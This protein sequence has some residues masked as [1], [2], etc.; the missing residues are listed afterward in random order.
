[1]T[2][3]QSGAA[4]LQHALADHVPQTD[5]AALACTSG[6]GVLAACDAAAAAWRRIDGGDGPPSRLALAS[7]RALA[8]GLVTAILSGAGGSRWCE[9]CIA[10]AGHADAFLAAYPAARVVCL[11]RRCLDVISAAL[12][13]N[14]WGLD[15]TPFGAFASAYPGNAVAAAAAYWD[16]YTRALLE[17]ERAH[18]ASCWRLK[19]EEVAIGPDAIPADLTAFLGLAAAHIGPPPAIRPAEPASSSATMAEPF[20]VERIPAELRRRIGELSDELG[21]KT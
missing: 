5:R 11:H 21:Y 10:P 6:T 20:P 2:Y 1:L 18:Q 16:A 17:F 14:P 12:R 19:Y 15:G 3:A 9:I 7:I 8:N 13:A 4:R